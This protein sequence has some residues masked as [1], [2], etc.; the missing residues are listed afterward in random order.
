MK[1]N[2]KAWNIREEDISE[3]SQSQKF[4]RLVEYAVL[5][6]EKR[7]HE[8][9]KGSPIGSKSDSLT[10]G[11]LTPG[12]PP[13]DTEATLILPR[14]YPKRMIIIVYQLT[15]RPHIAVL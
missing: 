2:Y 5:A 13:P 9:K 7:T 1:H 15:S 8:N 3:F 10:P 14:H 4:E 11:L 12:L 6:P